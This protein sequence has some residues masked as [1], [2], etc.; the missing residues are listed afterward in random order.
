MEKAIESVLEGSREATILSNAATGD[1]VRCNSAAREKLGRSDTQLRG[2]RVDDYFQNQRVIGHNTI[3]QC[4]HQHF[5]VEE[6]E[7]V[8]SGRPYIKSSFKPIDRD[9]YLAL[10][11]MQKR[12]NKLMVHRLSSPVNGIAGYLE[13]LQ[14]LDLSDRQRRY[15]AEMEKGVDDLKKVL[16][17]L[18]GL[19]KDVKA[20]YSMIDLEDFT[21]EL[22]SA[23]PR[24]ERKR[25][26]VTLDENIDQF[27]SDRALLGTMV[28][29]LLD[30]ALEFST[31]PGDTVDLQFSSD[32]RISITN[33]GIP[34]AGSE[35]DQIFYPFYSTKARGVGLGLPQCML[36]AREMG[37]DLVLSRNSAIRGITFELRMG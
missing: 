30:N 37:Y 21:V 6:E 11:E 7:V 29:E 3:W 5:E 35:I 18:E 9:H 26:E 34:I 27:R 36:Y 4:D 15:A 10:L 19:A 25:I 32:Y 23:Y 14:G 24:R 13:L 1:I 20:H 22:L 16:D 12:M 2:T 31:S 17:Q 8:V 28:R 33:S